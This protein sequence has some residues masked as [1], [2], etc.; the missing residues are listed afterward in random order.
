MPL[1]RTG[2]SSG[3]SAS[4]STDVSGSSSVC[5]AT[6]SQRQRR[7][8]IP[9]PRAEQSAD[10]K[11]QSRDDQVVPGLCWAHC[12]LHVA[13]VGADCSHF[14]VCAHARALQACVHSPSLHGQWDAA[15]RLVLSIRWYCGVLTGLCGQ[16]ATITD[17]SSSRSTRTTCRRTLYCHSWMPPVW[18]DPGADVGAYVQPHDAVG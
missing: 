5:A 7:M 14:M 11:G 18:A 17:R 15:Q 16:R 8:S 1:N 3:T 13:R 10:S 9:T 4:S 2:K 12:E 6:E